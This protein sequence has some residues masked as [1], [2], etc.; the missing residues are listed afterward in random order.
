MH[1][2]TK[3]S[4]FNLQ[5]SKLHEVRAGHLRAHHAGLVYDVFP[6]PV[7]DP[8]TKPSFSHAAKY[9]CL[10]CVLLTS[11]AIDQSRYIK[12]HTWLRGLGE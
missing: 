1:A 2:R 11:N 12:I 3:K 7:L 9:S 8:T 5:F 10:G 6:H 4:A